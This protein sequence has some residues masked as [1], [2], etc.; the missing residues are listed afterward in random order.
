MIMLRYTPK[1]ILVFTQ[2]LPLSTSKYLQGPSWPC[3]ASEEAGPNSPKLQHGSLDGVRVS[4]SC[5]SFSVQSVFWGRTS[6]C[7]LH[8]GCSQG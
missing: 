3:V 4:G 2:P 5:R 8:Q 7:G 6:F 1:M